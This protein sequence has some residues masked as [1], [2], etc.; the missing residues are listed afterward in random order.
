MPHEDYILLVGGGGVRGGSL[1]T[2][3]LV[4]RLTHSLSDGSRMRIIC[5]K[6]YVFNPI[7]KVLVL[8]TNG[9]RPTSVMK[10]KKQ[11][12]LL[13]IY[14]FFPLTNFL[15]SRFSIGNSYNHQC[16]HA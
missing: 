11:L 8:L 3:F 7:E 13:S 4:S 6:L 5:E 15:L 14:F 12:L 9:C 1:W 2:S 10:K 16:P